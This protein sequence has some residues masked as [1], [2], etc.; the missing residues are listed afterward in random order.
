MKKKIFAVTIILSLVLTMFPVHVV[1]A[2][3]DTSSVSNR[4]QKID[5]TYLN[6]T[7]VLKEL[8]ENQNNDYPI[9]MVH[10]LFGWGNDELYGENYWGGKSSLREMLTKEGY[11]V[12]T[13]TIGPISSNWDRACELYAYL[14]GGTVDYG[15]AH[16]KRYGHARYGR[17]YEGV[18]PELGG[19]NAEGKINKVH[20]VGHSM[21]GETIRVLAQLL[22]QGYSD[23]VA[24]TGSETSELF[25]GNHH[26]IESITTLSTPH[27]GSQ[28]DDIKSNLEPFVHDLFASIATVKGSNLSKGSF[29]FQ[30]DQWGLKQEPGENYDA[31]L[32]RVFESNIWDRTTDLSIYDLSLEGAKELNSWVKTQDDIY[33]YSIACSDTHKTGLMGR[34]VPNANMNPLL[35]HS[36]KVMGAYINYLPGKIQV[37]KQWWKNDGIVSVC[38]AT[39]PHIGSSDKSKVYQGSQE[40][41]VW[42]Y[43]GLIN[44]VDHIEVVGQ[45]NPFMKN[46]LRKMFL[47]IALLLGSLE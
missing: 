5:T 44:N 33:Y 45:A 36:S 3:E 12:Y 41:G 31:Y 4:P 10:G 26:W 40:R 28:Y 27:D 29:D 16:A 13:P 21:G 24:A 7:D 37:T 22:E 20:L 1:M 11:T 15:E 43:L 39:A 18:Y 46:T 23:E 30:M 32:S 6:Q 14:V 38:S 34:Y 8:E 47:H 42:N 25:T 19:N 9:V 17:T 35:C 2:S